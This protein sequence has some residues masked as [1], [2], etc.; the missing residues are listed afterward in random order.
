M[1][2][3]SL[4]RF[5]N[6]P[7]QPKY[8]QIGKIIRRSLVC[9][10]NSV[11][12]SI[13]IVTNN[14]SRQSNLEYRGQDKPTNVI[15]LEYADTRESF[16]MLT[17]ELVLADEVIVQEANEQGKSTEAHYAH[18][19]V[20]GMLHLQGYD[21]LDDTEAEEMEALEVEI[22]QSLGFSNPYIGYHEKNI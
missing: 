4:N 6:Y 20:H 3:F 7:Y 5:K 17:G 13:S 9:D 14:V 15:S 10:Y 18:M 21:H 16:N 2:N 11:M 12:I 22:L 19:L 8:A 1:I